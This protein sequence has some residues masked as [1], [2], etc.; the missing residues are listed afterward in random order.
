VLNLCVN[1]RDAMPA[2]GQLSI[3]ARNLAAGDPL[4]SEQPDVE[5]DRFVAVVVRDTGEGMNEA[6]LARA[7]EPFYTTKSVGKGTGLGLASV[8]GAMTQVGGR[9]L[10]KSR[11]AEGS[12]FTLLFPRAPAPGS[13]PP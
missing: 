1:A 8:Y 13:A 5:A 2:G 4:L 9:V 11:V 6:T 3:T 7:F 10:V 12:A